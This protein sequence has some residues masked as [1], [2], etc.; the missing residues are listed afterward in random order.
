MI[1]AVLALALV[2]ALMFAMTIGLLVFMR[3]QFNAHD[4]ALRTMAD[5]VQAP[6]R[7]PAGDASWDYV[8]PER[9][10]DEWAKVGS[11]EI[12]DDYGLED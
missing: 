8:I 6:E 1:Y 12:S 2:C 4:R 3:D 7:V 9:E 11:V 10:P 5:R